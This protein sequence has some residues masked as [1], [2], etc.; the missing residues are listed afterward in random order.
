MIQFS[1][2]RSVVLAATGLIVLPFVSWLLM[3][4]FNI[5]PAPGE[6]MF[7]PFNMSDR[8]DRLPLE[9]RDGELV[10]VY[11]KKGDETVYNGEEFLQEIRE[12]KNGKSDVAWLFKVLDITSWTSMA[13]VTVGLLGQAAFAGRMFAQW[14]AAEKAKQAVVPPLFWWMSLVG[15]SMLIIYFIWRKEPIGLLGQAAPWFIYVRNLWFIYGKPSS[16]NS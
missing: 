8:L 4:Q 13:W 12:R 9:E 15:S 16:V 14:L 6:A 1:N 10:V 5:L 2:R 11:N 3:I 7:P